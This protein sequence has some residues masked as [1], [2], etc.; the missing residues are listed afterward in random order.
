[1]LFNG[2]L[3][4]LACVGLV[5]IL[6]FPLGQ[7]VFPYMAHSIGNVQFGM[8]EAVVTTALGSGLYAALFS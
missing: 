1:M 2:F 5:L 4:R 7:Q 3:N 6:V 8:L